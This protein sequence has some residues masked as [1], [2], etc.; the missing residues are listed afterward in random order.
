L[1]D[2]NGSEWAGLIARTKAMRARRATR[3]IR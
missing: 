1:L 2:A 3:R